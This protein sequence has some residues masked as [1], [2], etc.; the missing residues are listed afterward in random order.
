MF[1]N[2]GPLTEEQVTK[3]KAA[4]AERESGSAGDIDAVNSLNYLGRY[5]FGTA[6]LEDAGYIMSGTW[7]LYK[8]NLALND[9]NNWLGKNG[10]FSFETFLG[11]EVAQEDAMNHLLKQNYRVGVKRGAINDLSSPED[12]AGFLAA[13]HLGGAGNAARFF[14][15]GIKFSDGYGTSIVEYVNLGSNSI[16]NS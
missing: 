13:A 8:S 15:E 7:A 11:N 10:A 14:V 3:L 12:V 1:M 9:P 5:Q 6:A 2:I 16:L 4:L